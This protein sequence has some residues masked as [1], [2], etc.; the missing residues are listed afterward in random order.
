M[1]SSGSLYS[2]RKMAPIMEPQ[3]RCPVERAKEALHGGDLYVCRT[4]KLRDCLSSRLWAVL[5]GESL[6]GMRIATVHIMQPLVDADWPWLR[7]EVFSR[8]GRS[9]N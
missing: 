5:P 4:P 2:S 7:D 1:M 9:F 6:A 8:L 3:V